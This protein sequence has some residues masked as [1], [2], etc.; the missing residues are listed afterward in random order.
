MYVFFAVK[1]KIK[2]QLFVLVNFKTESKHKKLA[3]RK[4]GWLW[5]LVYGS[6]AFNCTAKFS[7][8]VV[9]QTNTSD[10]EFTGSLVL[11][12]TLKY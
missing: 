6:S 5:G 2:L 4:T 1:F 9:Q 10:L 3:Y 8:S 7:L 12:L 11:T